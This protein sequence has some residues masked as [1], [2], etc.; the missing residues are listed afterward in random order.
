MEEAQ[1]LFLGAM[2]RAFHQGRSYEQERQH[3]KNR[4]YA[5]EEGRLLAQRPAP[6]PLPRRTISES[7]LCIKSAHE[8]QPQCSLLNRIPPEIRYR[9][10]KY[11]LSDHLIYL[12]HVD[13]AI[14][15]NISPVYEGFEE[16]G[17]RK[18]GT[19]G[20]R[21]HE[22][23]INSVTPDPTSSPTSTSA[24]KTP[25][26]SHKD[27]PVY[28]NHPNTH[29]TPFLFEPLPT[30]SWL[31]QIALIPS[32]N[33]FPHYT[34]SSPT[35]TTTSLQTPTRIQPHP[36]TQKRKQRWKLRQPCCPS[37]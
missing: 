16:E 22:D 8:T 37:P 34:H 6:L 20:S 36:H 15:A 23:D 13:R 26:T 28:H 12:T 19:K 5:E 14:K 33:Q 18:S 7:S 2:H 25:H 1:D 10:W 29:R 17:Q 27:K 3:K 21:E 4:M 30:I 24:L 31:D 32:P 11:V 35:L 9:I